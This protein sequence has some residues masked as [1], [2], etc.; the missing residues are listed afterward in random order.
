MPPLRRTVWAQETRN[1]LRFHPYP[2]TTGWLAGDQSTGH[3]G[4]LG[5][6][7]ISTGLA[8]PVVGSGV[9]RNDHSI[10]T[11]RSIIPMEVLGEIATTGAGALI[12]PRC[13]CGLVQDMASVEGLVTGGGVGMRA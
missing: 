1:C 13:T 10:A 3:Q 11:I 8:E 12:E 4:G 5:E 6:H 9:G 7:P 2:I